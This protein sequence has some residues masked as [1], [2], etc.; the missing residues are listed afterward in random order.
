MSCALNQVSVTSQSYDLIYVDILNQSV[1]YESFEYVIY[2]QEKRM[3]RKGQFKAPTVQ[4][5][6]N[7]LQEGKYHFQL[8]LHGQEWTTAFFEKQNLD[9]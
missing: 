2:N 4:I 6:T 5:R 8:L 9:A 7:H 3:L 1:Q